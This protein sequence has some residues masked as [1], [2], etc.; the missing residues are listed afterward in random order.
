VS[1]SLTSRSSRALGS[2]TR[3]Y[4]RLSLR[5]LV[6]SI[7]VAAASAWG[8]GLE[9]IAAASPA[10]SPLGLGVRSRLGKEVRGSG[11]SGSPIWSDLV[12]GG[13]WL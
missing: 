1:G 3:R 12:R 5:G 2:T 10:G 11:Q 13:C 7:S 6:I 4:S 9:S 8:G